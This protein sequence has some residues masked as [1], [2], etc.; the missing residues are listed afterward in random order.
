MTS[1][2]K[3]LTEGLKLARERKWIVV[4]F[5]GNPGEWHCYNYDEFHELGGLGF[6]D[7]KT[8]YILPN[9]EVTKLG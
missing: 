9:G 1:R 3:A 5:E 4:L 6:H 2:D 7:P 8:R